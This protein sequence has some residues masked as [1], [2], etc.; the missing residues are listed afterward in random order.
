MVAGLQAAGRS[1]WGT[2]LAL[3]LPTYIVILVRLARP[4]LTAIWRLGSSKGS[5]S[6]RRAL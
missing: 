1:R 2:L 4:S 6:S 5:P 3:C